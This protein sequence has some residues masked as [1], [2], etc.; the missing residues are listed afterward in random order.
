MKKGTT[1]ES[2]DPSLKEAE[3]I[4]F[5]VTKIQ[6]THKAYTRYTQE[7]MM[8]LEIFQEGKQKG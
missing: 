8:E 4:E 6:P 5:Y 1:S 2:K 3:L 7:M